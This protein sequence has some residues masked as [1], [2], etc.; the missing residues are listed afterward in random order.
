VTT[1][2]ADPAATA[3]DR[4]AITHLSGSED[5]AAGDGARD[6]PDLRSVLAFLTA[7]V[8]LA[9]AVLVYMG[10]AYTTA[11]LGHFDVSPLSLDLSVTEYALRGLSLFSPEIVIIGAVTVLAITLLRS[12]PAEDP[13]AVFPALLTRGAGWVREHGRLLLRRFG[14]GLGLAGVAAY[15]SNAVALPTYLLLVLLGAGPLLAVGSGRDRGPGGRYAY[16]L[17]VVTAALCGLWAAG[18]YADSRGA[19]AGRD[20]ARDLRSRT[21]AVVYSA[22]RLALT[23]PG[24]RTELLPKGGRYGYRYTGLRL[25]IAR[26]ERYYLLP[27]GWA[28]KTDATYVL[29]DGDDLRIELYA[30]TR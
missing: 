6:Q 29:T 30:G 4:T 26:G 15:L 7:N 22:D 1:H 18:L 5:P 8:G 19:Q 25:L 27:A 13:A 12:V 24:L 17:A 11:F 20:L 9:G 3:R 23:G 10:W 14:L 21:A 2:P 28:E 16:T